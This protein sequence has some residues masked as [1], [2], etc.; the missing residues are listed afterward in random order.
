M[1]WERVKGIGRRRLIAGAVTLG[2]A[3]VGVTLPAETVT[4]IVTAADL[5]AGAL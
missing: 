4:A 3:V 1:I 2:L 5:I